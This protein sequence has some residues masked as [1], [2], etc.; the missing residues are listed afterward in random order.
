MKTFQMHWFWRDSKFCRTN[1]AFFWSANLFDAHCTVKRERVFDYKIFEQLVLFL[2]LYRCVMDWLITVQWLN[3]EKK[4][5]DQIFY[6]LEDKN[7]YETFDFSLQYTSSKGTLHLTHR[8]L[9]LNETRARFKIADLLSARFYSAI[10]SYIHCQISH[11]QI[12]V[13]QARFS[14]LD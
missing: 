2:H 9:Y 6:W 13:F 14:V 7:M 8:K 3:F 1:A 11:F 10:F 12:C 5:R 4:I